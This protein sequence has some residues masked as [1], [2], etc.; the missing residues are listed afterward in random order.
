MYRAGLESIL[1][2]RRHGATFE[3]DPCVPASWPEYGITWRVG[4]TRY[5]ILVANPDRLCRGIATAEMDGE[6]VDSHAIALVDDGRVHQ[7][8]L[9]LGGPGGRGPVSRT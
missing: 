2:L 7:V 1:G 6:P 8:R 3:V 5:E 9:V 4:R